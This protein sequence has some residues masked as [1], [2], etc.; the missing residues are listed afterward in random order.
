MAR[1][2]HLHVIAEGVEHECQEA[3]LREHGCHETQGHL[4]GKPMPAHDM[5]LL[6]ERYAHPQAPDQDDLTTIS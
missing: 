1:N 6:L 3:F 5:T 2:L 4:Y